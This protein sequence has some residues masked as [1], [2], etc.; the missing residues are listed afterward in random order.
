MIAILLFFAAHWFLSLFFH[1]FFLHRYASHKMYNTSKGWEKTFYLLTW[2]FQGSSFLVPRAYAVMHRMHHT[3]SDTEQDPHS[4]HFFKDVIG[5][6]KHTV[7]IFRSFQT[8]KRMPDPQFTKEFIPVWD[9]LD[10]FG[11][12]VITRILFGAAYTAF[13]IFFAPNAW[14]FL[15]LPIH[16]LI[17]PIQ[18]AIVNWCG[19][20]YGYSNFDN[21][22]HSK[23]TTPWGVIMMGELFQNNHHKDKANANFARRW[24]EFDTTYLI[25]KALNRMHIIKLIPLAPVAVAGSPVFLL[26]PE[27]PASGKT[28]QV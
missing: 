21:H 2:F 14:W 16:F 17:G 25:M 3:Y 24:F 27:A 10:R 8:K 15:L 28:V 13:Y 26:Y 6:M 9:K 20:K 22:D 7:L 4:P 18:G 5:M 1:S 11:H 19:H 12:N 23:N